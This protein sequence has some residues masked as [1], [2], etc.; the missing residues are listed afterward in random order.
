MSTSQS[1]RVAFFPPKPTGVPGLDTVLGGGLP[2]GD[3]VFIIGTHGSGKTILALQMAFARV[4][5][6]CKALL[7]TAFSESHDKLIAHLSNLDFFDA[8]LV[9]QQLQF[10]SILSMLD[11]EVEETT[12]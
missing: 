4:R 7:L 1:P 3:L 5:S 11:E 10:L 12:R 6:G 2:T 8:S 9:G